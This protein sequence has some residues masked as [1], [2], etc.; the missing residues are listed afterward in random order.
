MLVF[1]DADVEAAAAAIAGAGYFNAGQDCTA[2]TRV[3]VGGGIHYDLVG[4]LK[5]QAEATVTGDPSTRTPLTARWN[6]A[7]QLARVEGFLDRAGDGVEVVTGGSRL[8]RPGFF[9]EPTVVAG[10][11]QE[12]R[13]EPGGG[14]RAGTI[15]VQRFDDE[16]KALVW[17][18]GVKYG[19]ASSV[20][21]R[22]HGRAMR[23]AKWLDYGCVWIN[24][25]IP[26]VA[27]MPHG[28][29]KQSG[30]G[31]DLSIYS[32]EEYTRVKHVMS[33]IGG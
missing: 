31:K 16:E 9:H 3:L 33:N 21:T 1:D 19:L 29:F 22:D 7:D 8:H 26:L 20:W 32:F 17:A 12:R 27:E 15:T 6:N 25:H 13:D 2:A 28:G 11:E 30:T 18:N 5:D 4:A 10:L 23:M 14:I 24:C